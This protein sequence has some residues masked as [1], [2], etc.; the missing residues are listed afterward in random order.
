V[1]FGKKENSML[2]VYPCKH[3]EVFIS[4]ILVFIYNEVKKSVFFLL[5][6]MLALE[7]L[8]KNRGKKT[9]GFK[10]HNFHG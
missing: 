10:N 1:L 4:K 3:S 7:Q 5:P 9:R 2:L 8:A 6:L